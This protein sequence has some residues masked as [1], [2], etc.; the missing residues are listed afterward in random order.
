MAEGRPRL[1]RTPTRR[2]ILIAS[3]DKSVRIGI[4]LLTDQPEFET[5]TVRTAEEALDIL[6]DNRF[7]EVI[8]DTNVPEMG[9]RRLK[10]SIQKRFPDTKTVLVTSFGAIQ[11][12]EDI[13]R[14]GPGD[15]IL[16]KDE[17]GHLLKSSILLDSAQ[18]DV[19]R[20]KKCY[21][22]S[23]SLLVNLLEL[24]DPFRSGDN[25]Y[26][27][28]YVQL[29]ADRMSLNGDM[30][31]SLQIATMFR[32]VW[33]YVLTRPL[34]KDL[35]SEEQALIRNHTELTV[36]ILDEIDFPW[37]VKSI[38]YHSHERYDGT[39]YPDG[40][41]GRAI[42]LGAR[43]LAIVDAYQAMV[44][45]RPHR[46]AVTPEAALHEL[47]GNAGSQF[48][49]EIVEFFVEILNSEDQAISRA[50]KRGDTVVVLEQDSGDLS[51][52]RVRLSA[53]GYK[54]MGSVSGVEGL[55]LIKSMHPSAVLCATELSDMDA[56]VLY[57]K[58]LALGEKPPP[59]IFMATR[60]ST[61]AR[62][63]MLLLGAED[64]LYKPVNINDLVIRLD[65]I[66]KRAEQR[67]D[68]VVRPTGISGYIRDL[69]IPEI[70]QIL[71]MGR[72]TALITLEG[73]ENRYVYMNQ[74]EIVHAVSG[75]AFGESA[76]L[77][78]LRLRDSKFSITHGV[79][80]EKRTINRANIDLL[81]DGLR[82]M[83]EERRDLLERSQAPKAAPEYNVPTSVP[84]TV[85]PASPLSE[86]LGRDIDDMLG[87]QE[88]KS[89]AL[90][91]MLDGPRT[92]AADSAAA[93]RADALDRMLDGPSPAD[94]VAITRRP[95][96]PRVEEDFEIPLDEDNAA[97]VDGAALDPGR[98][99]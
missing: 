83:D 9:G 15:F 65:I 38:I 1:P 17:V 24:Q 36:R 63:D 92:D 19:A 48:D 6:E 41:K 98:P 50:K 86:D 18:S 81:L 85:Q 66:L 40:V 96:P 3:A 76:F 91:R 47:I 60:N 11:S 88:P 56:P 30:R 77:D 58:L 5:Y 33:R 62:R 20:L 80:T 2:R 84:S 87:S 70:I 52:L 71:E 32:D 99:R 68:G 53:E 82:M 54:V 55:E 27:K 37:E 7:D 67:V 97:W 25:H 95:S 90:D 26:V 39:G 14:F 59:V 46:A 89:D 16:D 72:K 13:L 44:S 61:Y 28:R 23:V 64:F 29:I 42:P 8:I 22:D 43:I 51:L 34:S 4:S 78:I 12:S 57:E 79:V 45:P 35:S 49:P 31:D 10:I 21:L 74:G 93:Q 73:D 69:S 94:H 75:D